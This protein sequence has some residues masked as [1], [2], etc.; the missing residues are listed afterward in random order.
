[1]IIKDFLPG[2]LVSEFVQCYRIV[3]FEF[4]TSEQIPFKAYPPK[5]ETCLY[6]N[7]Q[8]SLFVEFGNSGEKKKLPQTVLIGQQTSVNYRY[9]RKSFLNFQVV[10][11]PTGLFRLTGIPSLEFTNQIIDA[12]LIFPKSIRFVYE[13]LQNAISYV[14]MLPVADRFVTGLVCHAR[15]ELH[16]LDSV[17]NLMMHRG[18]TVSMDW[19]ANESC[20]CAKQFNRK[21][22]ERAGVNPKTFARIIRFTKAFNTRNANPGMNWLRI[23]L[24]CEYFDYQHLV[25]DY[26][27]LTGITPNELHLLESNSPEC[28]LGM[29]SQLYRSRV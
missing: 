8:D 14:E 27:D 10:F 19:L 1:M 7:L 5:P 16:L 22:N 20:L 2:P 28:R 12:E 3:H 26:K 13:E 9:F 4:E 15:R 25:K 6:F 24:E 18:G 29:S 11:K 17:S 21:F 23:A